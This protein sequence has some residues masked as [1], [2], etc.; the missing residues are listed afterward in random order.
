MFKMMEAE[1]RDM[2]EK[3]IEEPP[4]I[5]EGSSNLP[6]SHIPLLSLHILNMF[7]SKDR[8]VG[9]CNTTEKTPI[10]PPNR[11]ELDGSVA[12]ESRCSRRRSGLSGFDGMV[13]RE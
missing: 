1:R 9:R 8:G 11:K 6:L 7:V 2:G 3:E 5:T 4:P 10:K 13:R 12:S